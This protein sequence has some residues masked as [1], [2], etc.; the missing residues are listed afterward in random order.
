MSDKKLIAEKVIGLL[1]KKFPDRLILGSDLATQ[2]TKRCSTGSLSFDLM[3]GGGWPLNVWNEIVGNESS[4]KTVLALKTIAANQA[5]DPKY[6]TLWV[7]SEDFVPSWAAKLGVD[8]SRLIVVT[9]SIMEEAFTVILDAVKDRQ[10]DA[11]V[12]D[13]L[14]ALIPTTVDEKGI[15]ELT[16]SAAA[17]INAVFFG[18]KAARAQR[19]SLT[20]ASDRPC[21]ALVINQWRDKIGVMYGDPR[22][23]PGGKVK[24]YA[25]FTRVEVVRDNWI[26]LDKVKVGQIIKARTIKN[27]TAPPYRMGLVDFYF[28]NTD[29]FDAG[30]YDTTKEV[31]TIATAYDLV[32]RRGAMYDV[33][34]Q[35][36]KGKE[37][38]LAGIRSDLDLKDALEAE[39]R[40]LVLHG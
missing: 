3:L 26:E 23:T 7:A 33:Q 32:K 14:P 16:V 37:E 13:S 38:L 12:I 25:Y 8:L 35:T 36:F 15:D 34:G 39:I 30:D 1:S 18:G 31:F 5:R 6:T 9:T 29:K 11:V 20:D 2:E 28:S 19:R 4:G 40:Q 21:L 10:V 17:R 27:K 22:T 24:N